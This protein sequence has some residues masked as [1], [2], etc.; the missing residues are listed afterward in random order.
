MDANRE[1]GEA[2]LG[3]PLSVAAFSLYHDT[4]AAAVARVAAGCSRGLVID[5]HGQTHSTQRVELGYGITGSS[6]DGKSDAELDSDIGIEGLTFYGLLLSPVTGVDTTSEVLRGNSSLGALF[7]RFL[8]DQ[9]VVPGLTLPGPAG[10]SY[11][12]GG[13][14][15]KL[16]GRHASRG[17]SEHSNATAVDSVQFELNRDLR[18]GGTAGHLEFAAAYASVMQV[19]FDEVYCVNLTTVDTVGCPASMWAHIA[20]CCDGRLMISV[21]CAA[22][23]SCGWCVRPLC[24]RCQSVREWRDLHSCWQPWNDV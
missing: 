6:L 4:L 14:I 20:V 5:M 3:D 21:V 23:C 12:T 1:V 11:F 15:S 17:G 19:F 16:W 22:V 13:Y 2:T 8:P 10:A 9:P 24:S 18:W 7:E